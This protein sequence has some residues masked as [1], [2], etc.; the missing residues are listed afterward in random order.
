NRHR[1]EQRRTQSRDHRTRFHAAFYRATFG[2][3]LE[4][5]MHEGEEGG[6]AL[7]RHR[8]SLPLYVGAGGVATAAHYAVTIGAVEGL[9]APPVLASAGGFAVGAAVKYWLNYSVA[10]RSRAPHSQAMIRFAIA[11][12]TLMALNTA[13]FAA[14]Q[15]GL[16]LHYLV[17]QV[18]TTIL[19]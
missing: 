12:A 3:S 17:A 7:P 15:Q 2:H 19:L 5:R 6:A 4:C 13:I 8:R 18:I 10:F 16:G 9:S 11:L 1:N 14:L